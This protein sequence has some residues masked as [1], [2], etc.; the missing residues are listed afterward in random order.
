MCTIKLKKS[1]IFTIFTCFLSDF[2]TP[3][4]DFSSII[5]A[6]SCAKSSKA[7]PFKEEAEP[8]TFNQDKIVLS[9]ARSLAQVLLE[10]VREGL[11]EDKDML[12]DYTN[13]NFPPSLEEATGRS[14]PG[15][16]TSTPTK[17]VKKSP[18][19]CMKDVLAVI[20]KARVLFKTTDQP[21]NERS[22]Q[23]SATGHH[24]EKTN[25]PCGHLE[26][27]RQ[28][29]RPGSGQKPHQNHF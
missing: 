24:N 1:C 9:L 20:H 23:K 13:T 6:F 28:G 21:A 25:F 2:L 19:K 5:C 11:T 22:H 18:V 4:C 16:I 8:E 27:S 3:F 12:K 10:Q 26:Y 15:Q 14:K 17:K 29:D 7:A